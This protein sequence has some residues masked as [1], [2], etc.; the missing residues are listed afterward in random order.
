MENNTCTPQ[1]HDS[2]NSSAKLHFQSQ[3]K[4]NENAFCL[5]RHEKSPLS[6][7]VVPLKRR[8]LISEEKPGISFRNLRKKSQL[9]FEM[10][11]NAN[12][13]PIKTKQFGKIQ[14]HLN[15][16]KGM[17]R[18]PTAP[19]TESWQGKSPGGRKKHSCQGKIHRLVAFD[20][21]QHHHRRSRC[22]N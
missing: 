21:S 19:T 20:Y 6:L 11:S 9:N 14:C 1:H 7:D 18:R 17:Q 4:D 16:S 22:N 10:P 13:S 2:R 8:E 15:S 3:N 5:L 12:L